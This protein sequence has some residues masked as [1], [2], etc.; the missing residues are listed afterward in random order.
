MSV[1]ARQY[2]TLV[3]RQTDCK[4]PQENITRISGNLWCSKCLK[5]LKG[6]ISHEELEGDSS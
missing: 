5:L 3:Q 2:K 1:S 6:G 4:H